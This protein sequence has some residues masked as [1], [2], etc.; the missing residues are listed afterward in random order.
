[1][2]FRQIRFFLEIVRK[3]GFTRAAKSLNIAQPSLS[4]AIQKLEEELGV[5]LLNRQD[6]KLS[7]TAEGH[8]FFE[9]SQQIEDLFTSI[10]Q[11]MEEYRGLEKGQIKLGLPGMLAAY[12]FPSVLTEFR[13]LY[14][15]IRLS[16]FCGGAKTIQM[17]VESGELDLGI[18]AQADFPDT[19]I[20]KSLLQEEMVACVSKNHRL[21]GKESITL[22]ELADEP[23]YLLSEGYF[24]RKYLVE[25]LA[26][27]HLKPNI[28][29]ETNLVSLLKKVLASGGGVSTFLKMAIIEPELVAISFSPKL[30]VE[31]VTVWKRN[32]FLSKAVVV[33]LEYVEKIG[34]QYQYDKIN[35]SN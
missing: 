29:F 24:Q 6:R 32:V 34:M 5:H 23:L 16:I 7:L 4:I 2:E 12:F 30:Y 10:T 26:Q 19:L 11:E 33:F 20:W 22:Q 18:V 3:K 35:N 17:M 13:S 1:V 31:A 25:A 14:P 28:L 9:R 15:K 21:S 27:L 8:S